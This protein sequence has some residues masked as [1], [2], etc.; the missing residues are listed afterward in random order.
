MT[1][2]PSH[3]KLAA[4]KPAVVTPQVGLML[5]Y[6]WHGGV[7]GVRSMIRPCWCHSACAVLRVFPLLLRQ[8]IVAGELCIISLTGVVLCWW[9]WHLPPNIYFGLVM[10]RH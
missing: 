5:Q 2:A 4:Q 1:L 7:A 10:R 6:A 3:V 9:W 8:L